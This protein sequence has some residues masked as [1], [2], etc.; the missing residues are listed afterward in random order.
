MRLAQESF[1]DSPSHGLEI[2]P[3]IRVFDEQALRFGGKE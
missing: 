2:E 1:Q 3:A